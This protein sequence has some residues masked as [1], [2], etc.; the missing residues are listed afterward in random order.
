MLDVAERGKSIGE[1]PSCSYYV[2]L[3]LFSLRNMALDIP[4]QSSFFV[5]NLSQINENLLIK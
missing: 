5:L 2:F 3:K 1:G 4:I